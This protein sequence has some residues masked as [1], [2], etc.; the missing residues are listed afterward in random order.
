MAST[1]NPDSV[2]SSSPSQPSSRAARG[3]A[4]KFQRGR[5]ALRGPAR[6][7]PWLATA[8]AASRSQSSALAPR[9]HNV[10]V[11]WWLV[12]AIMAAI[13]LAALLAFRWFRAY[14]YTESWRKG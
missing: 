5:V 10:L 6:R 14:R 7:A 9:R 13:G 12:L 1:F 8:D 11:G 4:A 3:P 2:R